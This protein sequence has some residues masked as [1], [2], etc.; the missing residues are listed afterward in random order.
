MSP[1]VNG[2]V[3]SCLYAVM[4]IL[5]NVKEIADRKG[6]SLSQ[7]EKRAGLSHGVIRRWDTRNPSAENV[8]KVSKVLGVN[9]YSLLK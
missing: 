6:L 2:F 4:N 3:A 8:L 5:M 7:I 9:I 1:D